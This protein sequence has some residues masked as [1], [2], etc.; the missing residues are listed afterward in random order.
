VND[1]GSLESDKENPTSCLRIRGELFFSPES[2]WII[3]SKYYLKFFH[4]VTKEKKRNLISNRGLT[5]V[6]VDSIIPWMADGNCRR[7]GREDDGLN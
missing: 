3:H 5:K 4:K 6:T 7:T 2:M 1:T